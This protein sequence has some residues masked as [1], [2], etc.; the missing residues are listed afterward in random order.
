MGLLHCRLSG[1]FYA[2]LAIAQRNKLA[3]NET[4]AAPDT[5]PTVEQTD[6]AKK[7]ASLSPPSDKPDLPRLLQTELRRVGCNT[8]AIDGDWNAAAQRAL[9]LF[10]KYASMNLDVKLAS[11]EALE[12]VEGRKTRICPLIC[13]RGYRPEGEICKKIICTQ[14]SFL[15][16]DNQC[17]KTR[18]ESHPSNR[19]ESRLPLNGHDRAKPE[20]EPKPQ[21][22]GQVVCGQG[23][24]RPIQRG[25]HIANSTAPW[26]NKSANVEV[27]N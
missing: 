23:G 16:D 9:N 14:G 26:M 1:S 25:C 8:G 6:N 11:L 4:K 19:Q 7:V 24:C 12:A 22:S 20:A 21:A 13:D 15:N 17:E 2:K 5:T 10:N 3:V 18:R 27:C